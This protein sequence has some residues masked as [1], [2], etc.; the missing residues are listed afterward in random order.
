MQEAYDDESAV[1]LI[2]LDE[3]DSFS[4]ESKGLGHFI[5]EI[6]DSDAWA[7]GEPGSFTNDSNIN[8]D[9]IEQAEQYYDNN[10]SQVMV[11]LDEE[12]RDEMVE[13]MKDN[14]VWID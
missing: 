11:F 4:L 2:C 8:F 9:T 14:N 10:Y 12:C 3:R 7:G 1:Y 6:L 5:A 13:I